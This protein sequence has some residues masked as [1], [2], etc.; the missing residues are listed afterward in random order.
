MKKTFL[1]IGVSA[2][3]VTAFLYLIDSDPAYPEFSETLKEFLI[4]S[5]IFFG[6]FTLV[7]FMVKYSVILV[8]KFRVE[9]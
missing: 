8:K 6:I 1:I 4:V 7:Y 2:I 9:E 3:A 5:G